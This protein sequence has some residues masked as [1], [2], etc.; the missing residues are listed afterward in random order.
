MYA[1]IKGKL[2]ASNPMSVVIEAGPVGYQILIP[3]HVFFKLPPLGKEVLLYTS[4]IV[5]ELSHTLYGFLTMQE[6]E[7]YEE[8]MG[9]TGVGPKVALNLIGH[10]PV[11]EMQRAIAE[12]DIARISKVPGIGKKTAERLIV[13]LRD[14]LNRIFPH[15]YALPVDNNMQDAM[16]ALIN[17]GYQ[18]N[19]A[20]NALKKSLQT[21]PEGADVV[22]LITE[23]LKNV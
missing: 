14:K 10:L 20:S 23:A 6:R 22:M 2:V 19:V 16:Q 13:E 17:L 9:V 18:Q 12:H 1:Y 8:L 11:E 3:A 4:F 15:H 5:R 21:L 7:L